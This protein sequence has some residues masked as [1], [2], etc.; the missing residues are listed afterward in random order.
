MSLALAPPQLAA[1]RAYSQGQLTAL[2]LR[3]L[4]DGAIYGDILRLLGEHDLPLPKA[5]QHGREE[6]LARA[7]TWLLPAHAA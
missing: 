3:R 7:R 2:E 4:L 5:P 1:L 6:N